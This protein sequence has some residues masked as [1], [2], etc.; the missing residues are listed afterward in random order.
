M[1]GSVSDEP[2]ST[3]A[4]R[5]WEA[6]L[7]LVFSAILLFMSIESFLLWS[8]VDS[9][10]SRP[11]FTGTLGVLVFSIPLYLRMSGKLITPW[12]LIILIYLSIFLHTWGDFARFYDQYSW[13]DNL[14]HFV[15]STTVAVISFLAI[16]ILTH[17][18]DVVY[19]PVEIIPFMVIMTSCFF[20]VTWELLEWF[21]DWAIGT[22]MQYSLQD[23]VYDLIMD[24]V[25]GVIVG[26]V[27]YKYLHYHSPDE[28]AIGLGI[29]DFMH[30]M[31]KKWA[32]RAH[33]LQN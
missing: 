15:S 1:N 26:S 13:W 17:Y 22:G 28:L 29:E 20:G 3:V 24:F 6:A 31:A 9:Y 11:A 14:T 23:T 12:P 16:V 25:G 27:G 7:W 21:L 33:L 18:V 4:F 19:T 8:R 5:G 2:K 32:D 30:T 10:Y